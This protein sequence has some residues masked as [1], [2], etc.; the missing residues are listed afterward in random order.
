MLLLLFLLLLLL[1]AL[2]FYSFR[3]AARKTWKTNLYEYIKN[4]NAIE[5]WL[6]FYLSGR[7]DLPRLVST[8]LDLPALRVALNT[9]LAWRPVLNRSVAKLNWMDAG[10]S[11]SI[12]CCRCCCWPALRLL[13]PGLP[14]F[15]LHLCGLLRAVSKSRGAAVGGGG[16]LVAWT[17]Y[18]VASCSAALFVTQCIYSANQLL[19]HLYILAN[20]RYRSIYLYLHTLHTHWLPP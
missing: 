16:N 5:M 14:S 18:C 12:H 7:K 6:C 15:V 2:L 4:S 3:V 9:E 8:C 20:I 19:A 10:C 13:L 17:V 11:E 1:L